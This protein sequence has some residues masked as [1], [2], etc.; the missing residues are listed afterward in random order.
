MQEGEV[1]PYASTA[2]CVF[3]DPLYGGSAPVTP[4]GGSYFSASPAHSHGG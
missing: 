1:S 2:F 3:G 4:L